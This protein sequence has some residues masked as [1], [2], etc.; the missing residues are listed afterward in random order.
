M[1]TLY[2]LLGTL[3]GADADDLRDAFRQAVKGAHPDISPNDPDAALKFRLIVYAMEVL[4]DPEQ[5]A[6][7]DHLLELARQ[8][9]VSQRI[10]AKIR[11]FAFAMISLASVFVVAVG[12]YLLFVPMSAPPPQVRQSDGLSGTAPETGSSSLPDRP[13]LNDNSATT[14]REAETKKPAEKQDDFLTR[15]GAD[16]INAKADRKA[17][18][19]TPA[20][21]QKDAPP[22]SDATDNNAPADR[23]AATATPA[24]T[25]NDHPSQSSANDN[26]APADRNAATATK[27]QETPIAPP[28]GPPPPHDDADDVKA[29]IEPYDETDPSAVVHAKGIVAYRKGDLKLA[30]ADFNRAIELNPTFMLAYINRGI[31]L[32]RMGQLDLALADVARARRIDRAGHSRSVAAF[33]RKRRHDASLIESLVFVQ[34]AGQ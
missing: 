5:R 18:T 12:L 20:A 32:Y 10:A 34:E 22:R 1:T 24:E 2:D 15:W 3:P 33:H 23:N 14:S 31:V 4:R 28:S 21:P 25:P 19:A 13:A 30:L 8:E 7:Y 29:L 9:L 27:E 26:K 17:E 16:D 6:A 11:N